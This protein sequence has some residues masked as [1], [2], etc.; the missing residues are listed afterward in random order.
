LFESIK[1]ESLELEAFLPA[2]SSKVDSHLKVITETISHFF[3]YCDSLINSDQAAYTFLM[4]LFTKHH[5]S[6]LYGDISKGCGL[7]PEKFEKECFSTCPV[8]INLILAKYFCK[9]KDEEYVHCKLLPAVF[10]TSKQT[11]SLL[12]AILRQILLSSPP[13]EENTYDFGFPLLV[14]SRWSLANSPDPFNFESADDDEDQFVT[15][16]D[17]DSLSFWTNYTRQGQLRIYIQNAMDVFITIYE[18]EHVKQQVRVC[19]DSLSFIKAIAAGHGSEDNK[20]R[21][22]CSKKTWAFMQLKLLEVVECLYK[23]H[24]SEK[25]TANQPLATFIV[26][27]IMEVH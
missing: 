19:L 11:M 23:E 2:G 1:N 10:T 24:I 14:Y 25:Q 17:T 8:A 6:R 7:L 20:K 5:L 22:A 15:S 18:T 3:E 16:F 27:P 21:T 4:S 26:R 12:N 13:N 9:L